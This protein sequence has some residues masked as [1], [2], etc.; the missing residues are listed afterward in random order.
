MKVAVN[1]AMR[2]LID[3]DLP[4]DIA[5]LLKLNGVSEDLLVL[6]ITE[7]AVI[8]DPLRTEAVLARLARM[9]VRIS[10]DD[11]GTGYSSLTYLTRLPIDEIKIDRSFVT[12]MNTSADKEVVVR[13]TIDLARNLGKQVVAE[14]VETAGVLQ[15]LEELGCHLVQGYFVSK[16]LPAAE[17]DAWLAE[18]AGLSTI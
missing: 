6:E 14:G 4:G 2:N 8:S 17:L 9:G 12:N 11:F 18:S 7:S 16:P 3:A 5:D 13:S 15:R 1:L 10:V